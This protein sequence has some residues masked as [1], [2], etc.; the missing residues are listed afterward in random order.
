MLNNTDTYQLSRQWPSGSDGV[1]LLETGELDA[2]TGFRKLV[3]PALILQP[4]GFLS[5]TALDGQNRSVVEFCKDTALQFFARVDTM[6]YSAQRPRYQLKLRTL[7]GNLSCTGDN[8]VAST[9]TPNQASQLACPNASSDE[10]YRVT[11][12]RLHERRMISYVVF[13]HCDSSTV[14]NLTAAAAMQAIEH[15]DHASH[16]KQDDPATDCRLRQQVG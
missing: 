10:T 11:A 7:A 2:V 6:S 3:A 14:T 4:L 15:Y 13:K 12:E 9:V 5:K 8:S 1:S 16:C